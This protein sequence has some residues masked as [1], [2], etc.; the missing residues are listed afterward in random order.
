MKQ[1]QRTAIMKDLVKKI[2]SKGSLEAKNRWWVS[3]L[4]AKRKHGPT[5]DGRIPC[6]TGQNDWS[7]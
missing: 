7:T 4:L 6:K 5:Q 1:Q 3:E 2:R